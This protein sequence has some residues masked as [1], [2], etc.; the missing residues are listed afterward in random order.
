MALDDRRVLERTHADLAA[1]VALIA[2]EFLS[3]FQTVLQIDRP[4][5]SLFGGAE[6]RTLEPH[7][8]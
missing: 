2:S 8:V 6:I 5:V 4:A 3:G 7:P 1:D